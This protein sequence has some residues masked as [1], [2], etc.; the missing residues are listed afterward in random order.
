MVNAPE[1][2]T[3][4][5]KPEKYGYRDLSVGYLHRI[6]GSPVPCTDI[7]FLEYDNGIPI[8]ILEYK[9][10]NAAPLQRDHPTIRAITELGNRAN[11]PVFHVRYNSDK[12]IFVYTALNIQAEKIIGGER[13]PCNRIGWAEIIYKLRGLKL[14]NDIEE[15][16]NNCNGK[17]FR[18][19]LP[20]C[21]K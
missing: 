3:R 9:H 6:L 7:D 15:R 11:I 18:S 17:R 1:R 14:P 12:T 8:A 4:A 13:Y 16:L 21:G 19:C 5:A 2:I 20:G 10:K